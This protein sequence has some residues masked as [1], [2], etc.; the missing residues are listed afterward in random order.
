ME[1]K[2]KKS[3][4]KPTY[5]GA[6]LK[7]LRRMNGLSQSQLATTI[8]VTRNKIASYESGIVEPNA[9]VFLI[10]CNYFKVPANSMLESLMSK[11]PASSVNL[12]SEDLNTLDQYLVDHFDQFVEK[13]NDMTKIFDGYKAMLEMRM[14]SDE[15]GANRDLYTSFDDLLNLLEMLLT[16]NWELIQQVMPSSKSDQAS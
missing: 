11:N 15:K 8:Q 12:E 5:F 6:N 3:I 1:P 7:F 4:P 16:S 10:V 14:A 9:K 2:K 13:T